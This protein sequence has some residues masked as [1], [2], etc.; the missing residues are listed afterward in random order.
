MSIENIVENE[1]ERYVITTAQMG[2]RPHKKF[3]QSLETYCKK[4][5][6]ELL[7]LP[8]SGKSIAEDTLHKDIQAYPI[9]TKDMTLNSNIKI[10]NYAIRPQQIN[11]L[12]GIRRFAQGDKSFIFAS[13]KQSLEYIPT[14]DDKFPKAV[15]TTGACTEP[16]YRL[17]NRIG[18]IALK[19]HTLGAVV[20][21]IENDRFFHFRHLIAQKN[22]LFYDL[23]KVYDGTK[24][25]TIKKIPAFIV[26]DLHPYDTDPR[27]EA[28]TFEQ[29]K[30]LNPQNVFLHDTF[31]GLSISHHHEGHYARQYEVFKQQGLNL[32]KELNKTLDKVK[33]YCKATNGIV[34]IVPSNHDDHLAQYLDEG[35]FIG[36]KGNQRI[37]ATL[38]RDMLDGIM[39]LY[40]GLEYVGALPTNLEFIDSKGYKIKGVELG[41]HGHLGA[42]G[43]RGSLKSIEEANHKSVTGHSHSACKNRNTY[44]V[45]TS[46][47]LRLS[48]NKGYSSWSQTNGILHENG[49]VQLLNTVGK[50]WRGK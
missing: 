1:M 33:S 11:P 15:M 25:R 3:L 17:N 50:N 31:N 20:V 22:G 36:D 13:T 27:H 14:A 43:G 28:C 30:A 37:G 42:N 48:Y 24:S 46:T 40:A 45:G 41:Q 47:K 39:P 23:N 21:E 8:T 10:S 2:V 5:D 4:N 34:R 12:T 35:R 19:D 38:F 49:N 26:G 29:I 18:R 32:E 16:N 44:K 9:I 6:A 7:I